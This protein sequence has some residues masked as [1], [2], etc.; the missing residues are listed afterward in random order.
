MIAAS[1]GL[2]GARLN[3]CFSNGCYVGAGGG[4]TEANKG[5]MSAD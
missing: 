2:V 1:R 4:G 3:K 5:Y